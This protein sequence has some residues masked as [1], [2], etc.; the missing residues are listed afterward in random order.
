MMSAISLKRGNGG[1]NLVDVV[2][3][4]RF[5]FFV[6]FYVFFGTDIRGLD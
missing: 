2:R 6:I 4:P 3:F 1:V 5:P